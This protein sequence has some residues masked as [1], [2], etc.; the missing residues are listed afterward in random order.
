[1]SGTDSPDPSCIGDTNFDTD[2]KKEGRANRFKREI[3]IAS[4]DTV[5]NMMESAT[6][7]GGE[8]HHFSD[9]HLVGTMTT[10]EKPY[11]RLTCA[12][13]PDQVRPEHILVKSLSHI[14]NKWKTEQNYTFVCEQLKSIRQDL[15]IQ[16]IQNTFAVKVYECH[17]RIALEKLDTTEYNQCQTRLID[18]YAA[19]EGSSN[20]NEFLCYRILYYIYIR[21]NSDAMKLVL[22]LDAAQKA[23][24]DVMF[25]VRVLEA[26]CSG[27]YYRFF[28]LYLEA[29]KMS[30]YLMDTYVQRERTEALKKLIKVY[31]PGVSVERVGDMLG[32]PDTETT[33][34]YLDDL[35]V[36]YTKPDKS[37]IDCKKTVIE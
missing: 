29:P 15:T 22:G 20:A 7:R 2:E 25:G 35:G 6:K 24:S 18:L 13:S 11:L 1:M 3:T 12:P 14:M 17:A 8:D 5:S 9:V 34:V 21:N 33:H 32:Y 16:N 4:S 30:G 23:A 19:N 31:K 27:N 36:V 10:L 28:R 26:W 37:V